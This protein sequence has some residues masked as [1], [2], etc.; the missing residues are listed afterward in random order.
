ME[1]LNTDYEELGFSIE[2]IEAGFTWLENI[3]KSESEYEHGL[4]KYQF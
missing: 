4:D 3:L 1:E 2:K